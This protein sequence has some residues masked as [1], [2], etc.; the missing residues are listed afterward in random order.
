MKKILI[1]M[2]L[3]A[4]VPVYA[5]VQPVPF[6]SPIEIKLKN[7]GPAWY[8][9]NKSTGDTLRSGYGTDSVFT[10]RNNHGDICF[11]IAG[12]VKCV[13]QIGSGDY[14]GG[15]GI[16]INGTTISWGKDRETVANQTGTGLTMP[17]GGAKAGSL[18]T[19]SNPLIFEAPYTTGN[20]STA[21]KFQ[22]RKRS[23]TTST[24]DNALFDQFVVLG[25]DKIIN[26]TRDTIYSVELDE[27]SVYTALISYSLLIRNA[28]TDVIQSGLFQVTAL[29]T[30]GV[31]GGSFAVL[32]M[33]SQ[34]FGSTLTTTPL[35]LIKHSPR[36]AYFCITYNS[37]LSSITMMGISCSVLQA[38]GGKTNVTQY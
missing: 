30:S 29:R 8:V 7:P 21:I 9:I 36:R 25:R 12:T 27:D 31:W 23:A 5:Q 14:V 16:Y 32:V 34:L 3:L 26:N 24:A 28:T 17:S 15:T 2:L 33:N 10:F 11:N 38:S 22:G 20:S 37:N 6:A 18:N 4:V 1:Y 35:V 13:S 19:G